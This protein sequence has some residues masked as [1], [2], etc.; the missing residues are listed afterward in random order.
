VERPALLTMYSKTVT[1]SLAS[2]ALLLASLAAVQV[3]KE[4][5]G[6]IFG[7]PPLKAGK[8]LFAFDPYRVARVFI[9]GPD[10]RAAAFEKKDGVWWMTMP[11]IDRA[12]FRHLQ[13][14]VIFSRRME[15]VETLEDEGSRPGSATGPAGEMESGNFEL[16]LLDAR[17][18]EVSHFH[19]G[20]RTAWHSRDPAS[21]RV[22]PTWFVRPHRPSHPP[23]LYVCSTPDTRTPDL[24]SILGKGLEELRDHR[25]FLFD[26]KTLA[27]LRIRN[28]NGEILVKRSTPGRPWFISK[29]LESRTNPEAIS[30]LLQG[31][32][33]LRATAIHDP[34]TVTLPPRPESSPHLEISMKFFK[35]AA[36]SAG[37]AAGNEAP[38]REG[39]VTLIL[40]PPAAAEAATTFATVSNRPAAIFELPLVPVKNAVALSELPLRVDE[41]RSRTLAT[42]DLSEL[43]DITIYDQHRSSPVR[44]RLAPPGRGT[45]PRW[46]IAGPKEFRP[47]NEF[48]IAALIEALTRHEVRAFSSDAASDLAKYGMAPPRKRLQLRTADGEASEFLLGRNDEDRFFA[49]RSGSSTVAEIEPATFAAVATRLHEWRDTLLMPFPIVDLAALR[50]ER[51]VRPPR[52]DPTLTLNYDF[53]L[54]EWSARQYGRDATPRLVVRRANKF[55]HDLDALRVLRWL[56]PDHHKARSAL[57]NPVYRLTAVFRRS[58]AEGDPAGLTEVAFEIARASESPSN[59]YYYGRLV[60][61]RDYFVMDKAAARILATPLTTP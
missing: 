7:P 41:L 15:V 17:G 57:R 48:A 6:T 21:G 18:H 28:T 46:M 55:V 2:A 13:R 40:E 34:G 30:R 50:I 23:R 52:A 37:G 25:P 22:A 3:R 8:E 59:Q 42:L 35:D 16:R 29:P 54:E 32:Y 47:A 11:T 31:L 39:L 19:L 26:P 60:G 4:D 1:I 27:R 38:L 53:L 5:L 61:G 10:G 49:M 43:R 51:A 58:D 36:S 9:T 45:Q 24:R 14:L 12:D 44:L 56:G 33:H 20:R